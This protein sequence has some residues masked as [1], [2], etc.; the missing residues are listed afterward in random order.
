MS[1]SEAQSPRM[2]LDQRV[3]MRDGVELSAD[4]Y[5]PPGGG[6]AWPAIVQRTPYD[7]N[8]DLWVGI[9]RFFA[10]HGYAFVTQDVRGR[11]DS[12]GKFVPFANE[13]PDGYDTIEWVATQPW[14]DGK[15][16][17]IGGSYGG[18]VQWA[19][20][21]ERPPHL[22]AIAASASGGRWGEELPFRFGAITPF[23]FWWLNIVGGRTVQ[24]TQADWP[25]L[26]KH[27]PLRDIDVALGRTNT[28]WREWLAHDTFDDYWQRMSLIGHFQHI[29]V[30]A[31][32]VTGWFDND[33]WG[34][35]HF[36]HGMV[37][38]SPAAERQWL[39]VG[40]WDHGGTR[41]PAQ[42]YGGLDFGPESV[43]DT[44]A[45]HLRFFDYWLKGEQ[46]GLDT[47]Q[48][49]KS[50]AMGAN[51]WSEHASWPPPGTRGRPFY[52]HSGGNAN[53]LVGDGTLSAEGPAGDEPADHYSYDPDDPTPTAPTVEAMF[54][55]E[56]SLD[57]DWRLRRDDVLVYTSE[58]L[59]AELEVSGHPF[60][61]LYAESDCPDTDWHVG[62][63][64]V[65]L[66][67]RSVELTNGC[68][69]AAYRGGLF[70]SPEPI[71]SG[72]VYEY[73]I[74][75]LAISHVWRQG[76]RLRVTLASANWP[77]F[78]RNPNTN[79]KPGDDDVVRVARNAVWHSS[80][81]PSHLLAPLRHVP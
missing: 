28:A 17:M 73:R 13:G 50:F 3:P 45:V 49:V 16:G 9:A 31:L 59:E 46:N 68:M 60:V 39:L 76:H 69:R 54:G 36:W 8:D 51:E 62:L 1:E 12:D 58:P 64:D 65:D 15:V 23:A 30:P 2:L 44:D 25:R 80:V 42:Q 22:A 43:V 67:G 37:T 81:Y 61:V 41:R 21:K 71:E 10:G 33:Q 52:L 27:R 75:L 19:A 79:A 38:E 18:Y 24:K 55:D 14:C 32:H 20:A 77:F 35:L 57:I 26:F 66:E 11:G 48:R 56:F 63:C 72:Q 70:A 53:T 6:S 5:L 34:A 29:A 78:A 47:D 74:E 40:P 7:N 4:V